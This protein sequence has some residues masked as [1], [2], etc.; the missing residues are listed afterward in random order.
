MLRE[1]YPGKTPKDERELGP[2]GK[3]K[4]GLKGELNV[5]G[6]KKTHVD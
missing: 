1:W 3:K 2:G 5:R 6:K 4:G